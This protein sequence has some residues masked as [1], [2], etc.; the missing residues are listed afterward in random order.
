MRR[1]HRGLAGLAL[2]LTLA[3]WSPLGLAQ[4]APPPQ[5]GTT[6]EKVGE[7]VDEAVQSIKRGVREASESIRE[8][9][10]KAK[11]SVHRMNVESRVYGRLHWD[12]ALTD[13]HIDLSVDNDGI[14][15]LRGNVADIKAKLKAVELARDTV[16]IA[17]V[18]DE[19]KV[20]PPTLSGTGTPP[21][22]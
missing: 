9:F 3:A 2:G 4:Q 15:T 6:G 21:P 14:A 1:A 11:A 19:L 16:G 10:A 18:V 13:A 8:Q 22:R 17:R 5:K 20:V 12:K 7:K